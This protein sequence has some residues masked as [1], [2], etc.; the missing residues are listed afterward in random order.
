[1]KNLTLII[2]AK[3][4][5]ESLPLVLKELKNYNCKKL[6]VL[7]KNDFETI[8]AIKNFKSIEI[9][10]QKTPGY[11]AALIEGIKK[12]KTKFFCIFNADGSFNPQE[13]FEMYKN[14]DNYD[15]VFA[16]RY[17]QNSGSEDD[18]FIT[19]LGNFIFTKLGNFF[20]NLPITDILFTYVMGKKS[21]I[22]ILN[23]KKNDFSY[24]VE[25][26]I[27]A[28]RKKIKMISTSSY[29]RKRLAGKKKV[30]PFKDGLKILLSM[31]ELYFSKK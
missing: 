26:P 28:F 6:I 4:E 9:L 3:S 22:K 1:M 7:D 2:P 12:C 8:N 21:C 14:L 23:L 29:E 18:D 17:Q 5:R 13:L 25:L 16:S 11:G 30:K 20:F 15:F 10:Y 27:K 31:F 19:K 24:C